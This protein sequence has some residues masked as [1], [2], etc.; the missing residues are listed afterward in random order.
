MPALVAGIHV[1]ATAQRSKTWMAG[2]SPAMT[3][4]AHFS[5]PDVLQEPLG[6]NF[7]ALLLLHGLLENPA[8]DRGELQALVADIAIERD[9]VA[10]GAPGAFAGDEV[11][12]IRLV[13]ALAAVSK[14]GAVAAEAGLLI[15]GRDAGHLLGR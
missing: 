15:F 11:G 9:L 4:R 8:A 5:I 3:T 12:E 14:F 1:L 10:A 6:R 2:T 7:P 13:A